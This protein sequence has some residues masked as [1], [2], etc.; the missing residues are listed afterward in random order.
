MKISYFVLFLLCILH[1][2]AQE[3][4]INYPLPPKVNVKDTIWSSVISD[5]YR[6]MEVDN[7]QRQEW[8]EAETKLT[9]QYFKETAHKFDLEFDFNHSGAALGYDIPYRS[10]PYY[11]EFNSAAVYYKDFLRSRPILLY[12]ASMISTKNNS[13]SDAGFS[14]DG[15]YCAL[16]YSLNGSDWQEVRVLNMTSSFL[17]KDH[18]YNVRYSSVTWFQNGFFY[19]K[20]DSVDEINKHTDQLINQKIYYHKIGTDASLDHVIFEDK[21]NSYNTFSL[22][23]SADERFVIISEFFLETNR[24]IT[25]AKDYNKDKDLPFKVL[26]AESGSKTNIIGSRE[27][28]LLAISTNKGAYNGQIIEI[29]TKKPTQWGI[30]VENQQ[31]YLI[32]QVLYVDDKYCT[33]LQEGFSEYLCIFSREGEV[34]KTTALPDGSANDLICYA[35]EQNCIVIKQNYYTNPPIGELFSLK[36]FSLKPIGKTYMDFNPYNYRFFLTNYRSKDGSVIPIYIVMSK[37]YVSKGPGAALLQIYGGFDISIKPK[38]NPGIFTLLNNGGIYAVANIRGGS[39]SLKNWHESGSLLNK[40]NSIDDTYYAAR[41][42]IDSGFAL[43]GKIALTGGSNGGL[44]AAATINQHPET[45]KAAI[46]SVGL[47][48]MLRYE[49]YTSG[50]YWTGEYG[51][52]NDS[53]QFKNLLSYSPLHNVHTNTT[54]PSMLIATSEYDDR[55]PPLHTYKYVAALQDLT[56]S[57]NPILFLMNTKRGHNGI[58]QKTFYSFLFRELNIK[59]NPM[60]FYKDR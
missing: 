22:N 15:K 28:T 43:S 4:Q 44:V 48:D 40:Q 10:G 31:K 9:N 12:S 56:H 50:E 17:L 37:D 29:D 26:F 8:L 36:D 3:S 18:I 58:N 30:V 39:N 49:N 2:S 27:D 55:V 47:Y 42:L 54:Y 41:F 45:F 34:L 32:K 53:L 23:V 21:E 57:P 20:Y 16:T 1:L 33:I 7:K 59:Y 25:F 14:K 24:T 52:I 11:I 6:P 46:L 19:S 38:F 51:S 35:P 13:F 60:S 5:P